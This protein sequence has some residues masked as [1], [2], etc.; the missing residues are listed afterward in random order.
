MKVGLIG[1]GGI[2]QTWALG[3][4]GL[5]GVELAAVA[6]VREGAARTLA[7]PVGAAVF[8]SA[9]GLID[10][11]VVDAVLVCTPPDT[12]RAIAEKAAGAGLHILCEKPLTIG[13]DDATAMLHAAR[14]AGVVLTMASKFRF[15][16]DLQRA[17]SYVES[18]AL[19]VP[20]SFTNSFAA[21]VAMGDRWNADPERS[22]GGVLIDNGTHSVDIARYLLGPLDAVLAAESARTE[23]LAVDET[24]RLLLR[25]ASGVIGTVFLSWSAANFA[26]TFVEVVGSEGVVRVGF[27]RSRFRRGSAPQWEDFGSGYDKVAAHRRQLEVFAG[28]VAGTGTLLIDADDALASVAAID[29]AYRSITTGTW[30]QVRPVRGRR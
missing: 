4:E 28:A 20:L 18:G 24:T 15:V 14:E 9:E 22:G 5:D 12:H 27:A 3:F 19:G 1:A 23:H 21:R 8:T 25:T 11:H 17:K 2:A 16:E 30:E 26:N 7:E 13:L 10:A 6:D 29:A